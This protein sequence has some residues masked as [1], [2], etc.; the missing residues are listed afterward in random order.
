MNLSHEPGSAEQSH[1]VKNEPVRHVSRV[2]AHELNNL[3]TIIQGYSERL[4]IKH[5]G[6]PAMGEHLK[7]I[8]EA[9]RRAAE[10]VRT[11]TPPIATLQ[12][13]KENPQ[14]S[15]QSPR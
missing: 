12:Q 3:F 13:T 9:S 1:N 8:F 2:V 10:I 15:E 7:R 5:G 4:L 6:D 11:A 14:P